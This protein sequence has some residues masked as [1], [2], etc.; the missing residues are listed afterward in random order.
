MRTDPEAAARFHMTFRFIDDILSA[1][2]A[3][4]RGA[5]DV[6][7][8]DGGLYPGYLELKET[9]QNKESAQFLG[10]NTQASGKRFLLSVYDKRKDFAFTVV[11]YPKM[12]SLIPGQIPY[13]VFV[14]L[15]WKGYLICTQWTDFL[16]YCSEVASRLIVNGC[17]YTKLCALFRGFA[18]KNVQKY[19]GVGFLLRIE[20]SRR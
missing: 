15:L 9:N 13:G 3:S 4:F 1:D 6:S 20:N 11:R 12:S 14:G 2:N 5:V 10:M 7:C 17:A 16:A 8:D 18:R 19:T